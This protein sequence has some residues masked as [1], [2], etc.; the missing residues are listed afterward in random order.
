MPKRADF[1]THKRVKIMNINEALNI[2]NLSGTVT[3]EEITK[4]YKKMAI[5][6]HPDRNPAGAEVMKAIN[7]A[8][9]FLSNLESETFT[10]TDSEN[11]Y[12]F[13]EELESIIKELKN[14]SGIIIE[15]CGNWIWVSGNTK[16]HKD[17]L[18]ALGCFWANQKK[19]WY[20]RPSEH[21]SRK[22]AKSW[23]MDEIR[24]KYGSSTFT[25]QNQ[26]TAA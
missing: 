19:K 4:A 13:S 14:L 25:T 7:A 9:E 5:K 17:T 24:A 6:Y 26:L 12:N 21:K 18:K 16:A 22:H 15:I 23:E 3:K 8:F 2:L 1:N 20:Y 11:A 10:H